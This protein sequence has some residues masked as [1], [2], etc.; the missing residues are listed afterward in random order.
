MTKHSLK[1]PFL[2]KDDKKVR[3]WDMAPITFL[4]EDSVRIVPS[5]TDRKG[6][7]WNNYALESD[8]WIVKIKARINGAAQVGADGLGFWYTKN[9]GR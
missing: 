5:I 9:K 2:L 8:E 1:P 3:F 6:H 7:I 4:T